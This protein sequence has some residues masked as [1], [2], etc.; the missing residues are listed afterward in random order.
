MQF[1]E[2]QFTSMI[3][4]KAVKQARRKHVKLAVAHTERT[5]EYIG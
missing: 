4:P 2:L 3:T 5:K 1:S